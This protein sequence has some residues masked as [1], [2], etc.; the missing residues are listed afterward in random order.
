[1]CTLLGRFIIIIFV[2]MLLPSSRE[3]RRKWS[4]IYPK[5]HVTREISCL[6]CVAYIHILP[7]Y[8]P[9]SIGSNL[10]HLNNPSS[11]MLVLLIQDRT[12]LQTMQYKKRPIR[13]LDAKIS[14]NSHCVYL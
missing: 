10:I 13:E 12:T 9:Q 3:L 2:Y 1:M 4:S 7:F 14:E 8:I 5:K 11:E 6:K